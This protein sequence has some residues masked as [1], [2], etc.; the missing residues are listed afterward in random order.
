MNDLPPRLGKQL[1]PEKVLTMFINR[2]YFFLKPLMPWRLRLAVRRWR[3]KRNRE[4]FADLWPIDPNAGITPPGW[5][6]WP[7]NK[8]FVLVLTHDVEGIKG[9]PR[10]EQLM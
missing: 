2:T 9:V 7:E 3:A 5:P 1:Q 8:R 10:V 4:V 6:A